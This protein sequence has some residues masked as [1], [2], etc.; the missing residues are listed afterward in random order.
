MIIEVK[1][2]KD[3]NAPPY[4]IFFNNTKHFPYVTISF[5][6][7]KQTFTHQTSICTPINSLTVR[8]YAHTLKVI[9]TIS[10]LTNILWS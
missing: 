1:F 7:T 8:I 10:A 3:D 4:I 9:N 5:V 6:K 2:T